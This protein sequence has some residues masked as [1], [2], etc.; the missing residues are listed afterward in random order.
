MLLSRPFSL[1]PW[2]CP[3]WF[4]PAH[5]SQTQE[6]VLDILL[7]DGE[8]R[9]ETASDATIEGKNLVLRRADFTVCGV[10]PL[11]A[12]FSITLHGR[13]RLDPDHVPTSTQDQRLSGQL[14]PFTLHGRHSKAVHG[15][16]LGYL[17][18]PRSLLLYSAQADGSFWGQCYP[19]DT[20]QSAQIGSQN[21]VFTPNGLWPATTHPFPPLICNRDEL[22]QALAGIHHQPV[23]SLAQILEEL[24]FLTPMALADLHHNEPEIMAG[25]SARLV[26]TGLLSQDQ[27]ERALSRMSGAVEVDARRFDID[28]SALAL[29]PWTVCAPLS[30]MP[31]VLDGGV[32]YLATPTPT[33]QDLAARLALLCNHRVE[34]AWCSRLDLAI[35]TDQAL[36]SLPHPAAAGSSHAPQ[37]A[38]E[39][40]DAS[41]REL[42]TEAINE[43]TVR[44]GDE[45]QVIFADETSSLV[46]FVRKMILDARDALASDI[47]IETNPGEE[48]ARIRF[49]KDGD[50]EPYLSVPAT[51][52]AALV[53]RIKVMARLDIAERRR[54]QDGKINFADFGG[55]KLEL[56]VA[57]LPTHNGLEDVVMRLLATSR[58]IP[59][60]QLGFLDRDLTLLQ[61]AS[62]RSVGLIL[63][64]GPT[65]SGKT[66]T[67]HSLLAEINT[68]ERKIWTAEDPIEITQPG[69]RQLQVNPKI[70]LT[71]ATAMRAFL[72]AD[73]DIIMIG[74]IRDE[75]TAR[76]AIEASLTGHLVLSTLHTNNAPESVV[77]LLDLGMDPM[78]FADSLLLIV[79]QRLV[80]ALCPR[81][82]RNTPL[83]EEAFAA[84]VQDYV[85][86]S[87][88]DPAQARERLLA[89]AQQTPGSLP[90]VRTATGCEHCHG[91]GYKGRMGIYE[92]LEAS[93]TIKVLIQRRA[94]PVELFDQASTEGM[95][96][97]RQDALEKVLLGKIDLIQARK[98]Y[99]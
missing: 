11:L 15:Q 68:E 45:P 21:W 24:E 84:L 43:S 20:L 91:S 44:H 49:R 59:L 87:H 2:P 66:T 72:R 26:Q 99:G 82:A 67:L 29:L 39:R 22:Q 58:P 79:A 31:L 16:T 98:A 93:P 60:R 55:P 71:F 70:G 48:L 83:N 17:Q 95:R 62:D 50:L 33:H 52:R 61:S 5:G 86:G 34:L 25:D 64:A 57:I 46:R 30:V 47:H 78:N 3:A 38:H 69:L 32:L 88:L 36:N 75:E 23:R 94:Q 76:I 8:Q 89:V 14:Q 56:R 10:W 97:L 37:P 51:L 81:C 7:T 73:P 9:E 53:S 85:Q 35:R 6:D 42:L 19:I 4:R 65:G 41:I 27:L 54:P 18:A 40:P 77:R 63:A 13:L 92:I 90:S 80:R 96:R 74:E 12:I 1:L 28:S